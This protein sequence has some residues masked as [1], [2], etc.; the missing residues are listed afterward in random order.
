MKTEFF[1]HLWQSLLPLYLKASLNL[2]YIRFSYILSVLDTL[3]DDMNSQRI[4]IKYL[5]L[6]NH[7]PKIKETKNMHFAL[8][9]WNYFTWV[10]IN[11]QCWHPC[12]FLVSSNW[13]YLLVWP[14]QFMLCASFF[15]ND[16][17]LYAVVWHF[18]KIS[19]FISCLAWIEFVR[20]KKGIH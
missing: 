4:K 6:C 20:L 11:Y 10:T 12:Y 8:Q 19:W 13:L 16:T 1:G 15:H 17:C 14:W 7:E 9:Y 3:Q 2:P 5:F 18:L